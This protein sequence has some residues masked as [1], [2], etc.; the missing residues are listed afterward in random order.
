M[1]HS[2]I[3]VINE[4]NDVLHKRFNEETKRPFPQGYCTLDLLRRNHIQT[5]TVVERRGCF[6]GA[7]VF[8][9]RLPVAQDY[10]HWIM[11]AAQGQAV[12][13]LAEP[14]GK[15]RWRT[16]SLM[17]SQAR[18]LEDYVR[19]FDILL[20]EKHI[21]SRHGGESIAILR[22][23]LYLVQRELAYFDRTEGR[24][25]SAKRRLA[26]LIKDWPCPFELYVDLLKAYLY[27]TFRS[28]S[29]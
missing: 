5:L 4:Q 25:E 9:E 22:D 26:N 24:S 11:I 21:K 27:P 29:E 19:I 14:L 8:D 12:G 15:Y 18:L 20:Q 23:R 16:G 3:S 17:G 13:Y 6:E 7:G 1:V 2:E 28:K 10:L